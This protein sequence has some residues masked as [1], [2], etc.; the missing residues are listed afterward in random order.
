MCI[1]SPN[2][3]P[4]ASLALLNATHS[5]IFSASSRISLL[6]AAAISCTRRFMPL[7][8]FSLSPI[9]RVMSV[10]V[11][12]GSTAFTFATSIA[13]KAARKR[14]MFS[15]ELRVSSISLPAASLISE[16]LL[17][18]SI[19]FSSAVTFLAFSF[20]AFFAATIALLLT[21]V[22][23]SPSNTSVTATKSKNAL[24][25]LVGMLNMRRKAFTKS[26]NILV[27]ILVPGVEPKN[28]CISGCVIP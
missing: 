7:T 2:S 9:Q 22:V 16:A 27:T 20:A 17:L 21:V 1:T 3:F 11:R 13:L 6:R 10:V 8:L 15:P 19:L 18:F 25:M 26:V 5:G 28:S 14:P 23:S 4:P 12:T 24:L